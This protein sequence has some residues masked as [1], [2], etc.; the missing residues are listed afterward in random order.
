MARTLPASCA[1]KEKSHVDKSQDSM[2]CLHPVPSH[3]GMADLGSEEGQHEHVHH[4]RLILVDL[5]IADRH[6]KALCILHCSCEQLWRG[7]AGRRV[8]LLVNAQRWSLHPLD[9]VQESGKILEER[10]NLQRKYISATCEGV[11]KFNEFGGAMERFPLDAQ[12]WGLEGRQ[13]GP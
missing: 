2:A 9:H 12:C 4:L 6:R 1:S 3:P 8:R 11:H 13:A 5:V 10:T 7:L